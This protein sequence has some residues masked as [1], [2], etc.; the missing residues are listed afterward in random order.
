M[1]LLVNLV[2]GRVYKDKMKLEKV[3]RQGKPHLLTLRRTL[4]IV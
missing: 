2:L 1:R 4:Q 3:K